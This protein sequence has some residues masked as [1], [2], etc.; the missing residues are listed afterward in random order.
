LPA[1]PAFDAQL[2]DAQPPINTLVPHI[3]PKP[4]RVACRKKKVFDSR[5]LVSVTFSSHV[6]KRFILGAFALASC[7]PNQRPEQ[8]AFITRIGRDT[9]AVETVTRRGNTL[10]SDAVDRFPRV[11]QRHSQI[12]VGPDGGIQHLV[13]DVTTPSEPENQRERH[14]VADVTKD[15]VLMV[16][17]DKEHSTRWAFATGGGTVM[18]HVPQMYSL[19][20]LYFAAGLQRIAATP[21]AGDTARLRQFY[22][23][24]EFDRFPLHSG[25]V[26]RLPGGKAQIAHDW[27]A[28]IGEATLDSN[29]R[30]L[31][32]SGAQTT[33]D[34]RVT[35]LNELPD[36]KAIG[37][38]FA[39]LETKNGGVKQLSVRDTTRG[40][41]GAATFTFDYGRPLA[42]GRDCSATSFRTTRC[43]APEP[44]PRRSSRR[45]RRSL[46]QGCRFRRDRTRSGRFRMRREST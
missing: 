12:T 43:G 31:S 44:M 30:M 1:H 10:T 14:I 35:R 23:D 5:V 27:L 26:R 22:I 32:Y 2:V 29:R 4:L 18:A 42:R 13:M 33:Y 3:V 36:V 19:Y 21:T 11:R 39:A 15:S 41:I 9:I 40:T 24:R 6:M 46:S 8:Y 34:V 7:G 25:V 37:A 16:K 17:R 28:G 20:E 45:R 38:E